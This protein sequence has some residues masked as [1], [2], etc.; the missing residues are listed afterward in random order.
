[1]LDQL[2]TYKTQFLKEQCMGGPYCPGAPP[3]PSASVGNR[4]IEVTLK[5]YSNSTIPSNAHYLWLRF[6]D[7]NTNQTIQHVSFF[8]TIEK[9]N[10]TLFR[11][12]LHT[13]TGILTLQVNPINAQFNGTLFSANRDAIL[14]GWVPSLNNEPIIVFAAL[15]ND[16]NST[17]HV[18]VQM[19]TIDR[20]NNIFVNTQSAPSFDFYLNMMEQNQSL[21]SQNV[22]VPEF[23]FAIPVLLVGIASLI[24]FYRIR[25]EKFKRV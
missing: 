12:L 22:T 11:E 13:H 5:L 4:K 10:F 25:I 9:N 8:L 17:Y 21:T 14:G 1:M 19:F 23:P 24:V 2:N 16:T 20:D 18:N 7:A 15:F 6:F 3:I